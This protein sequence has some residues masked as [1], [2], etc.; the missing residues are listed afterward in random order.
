MLTI[1][2]AIRMAQ[3]NG[4]GEA[5]RQQGLSYI[6]AAPVARTISESVDLAMNHEKYG[7]TAKETS[8]FLEMMN[9]KSNK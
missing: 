4:K 1:S 8:K 5:R 7:L 6:K 2:D 9:G 3:I